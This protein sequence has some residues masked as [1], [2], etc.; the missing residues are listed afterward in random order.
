MD[1]WMD[2][3]KGKKAKPWVNQYGKHL[4]GELSKVQ[5]SQSILLAMPT[6]AIVELYMEVILVPGRARLVW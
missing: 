3:G 6:W 1:G 2:S 5:C 4:F